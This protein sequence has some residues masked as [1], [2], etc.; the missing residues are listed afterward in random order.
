[1]RATS[2]LLKKAAIQLEWHI[3]RCENGTE[4]EGFI[5]PQDVYPME[6]LE[7]SKSVLAQL[8]EAING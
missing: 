2:D 1:V 3:E 4:E 6:R 5:S 7:M 8:K